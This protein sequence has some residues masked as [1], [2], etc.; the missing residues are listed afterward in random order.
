ML[1]QKRNLNLF[2]LIILQYNSG[3]NYKFIYE[4]LCY[5]P[6]ISP[7]GSFCFVN[8]VMTKEC[9]RKTIGLGW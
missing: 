2:Q 9:K 5:D 8:C 4:W 6:I 3:Y 1:E 7:P